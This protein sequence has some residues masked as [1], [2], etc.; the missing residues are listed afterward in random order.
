MRS[1]TLVY[2]PSSYDIHENPFPVYRRMQD[3]APLY[4][5]EAMGF[6]ALTRFEDVVSGLADWAHLSSARGTLIEQIQNGGSPPDMMI[7]HDP[8]RHEQLRRLIGRAFTPR[9]VAELEEKVRAMCIEWLDPLQ[10]VGG[11]EVVADLA[12]KLPMAVIAALLGAPAEDYPRLKA[13]SDRLLHREDG[14]M[15]MPEDGVAAGAELWA[16]FAE[17]IAARRSDPEDDLISALIAADLPSEN[18]VPQR[19]T[20][21]EIVYFCLLL[22]VAGN[23]TTAK[24]IATGVVTLFDFPDERQRIVDDP[25][26]WPTAVEELLRFDPPS[27]YQ[28]R[29]TTAAIERHGE[30]IPEGSIVLLINGAANRDPRVFTE[31]DRFVADRNIERHLAFGHSIHFCLGAPLAR[32]ETR[33]ALEELLRR[34]PIYEVDRTGIER[35]H[36]SNIRGLSRVPFGA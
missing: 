24:M 11:G 4:R 26:L 29:V 36:S 33:I 21:E 5:N 10:D 8:P 12:G 1:D 2:D 28:G 23:E 6:W 15:S 14:S 25:G 18:G 16:Y 7:F 34:F 31:P 30:V 19:L 35:F 9:R 13:L 32:M 3:E 17:L 27:H 20:E 22:G